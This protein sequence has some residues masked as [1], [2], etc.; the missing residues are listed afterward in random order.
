MAQSLINE[1]QRQLYVLYELALR[2][3]G[4]TN[5]SA[6]LEVPTPVVMKSYIFWNIAR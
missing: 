2:S 5:S 6:R 3:G 1:S 4:D